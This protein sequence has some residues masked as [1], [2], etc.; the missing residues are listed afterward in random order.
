MK[1]KHIATVALM[2]NLGVAAIYAQQRPVRMTYSGSTAATTLNLQPGTVTDEEHFAGS[3]TLGRFTFRQLRADVFPFSGQPPSTCSPPSRL[4]FPVAR[5][6]G[7]FR[8]QNGSLLKVEITGGAYCIDLTDLTAPVGNLTVAYQ[9]TGGTGRFKGASGA[10]TL[11]S[12]LTPVVFAADNSVK[13]LTNTGAF[14]G[15]VFGAA[16][17]DERD[18]ERQ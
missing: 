17:D 6:G 5:G 16:I 1:H 10:L 2:L 7:V 9:I 8:F 18:D 15:T 4:Y 11:N 12:T 14:E 13:L 3:G